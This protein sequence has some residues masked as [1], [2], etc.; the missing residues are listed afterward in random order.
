MFNQ[1]YFNLDEIGEFYLS[2]A[3]LAFAIESTSIAKVPKLIISKKKEKA[4]SK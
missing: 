3:F 1:S 2:M 4:L